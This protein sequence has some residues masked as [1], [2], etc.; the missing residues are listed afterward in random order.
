MLKITMPGSAVQVDIED[1]ECL[2]VAPLFAN[3]YGY[4]FTKDTI[5]VYSE[6][7]EVQELI[8]D[9]L[10]KTLDLTKF[11]KLVLM[12]E[13]E[14]NEDLFEAF[15]DSATMTCF[16]EPKDIEQTHCSLQ[17]L[18]PGAKNWIDVP[19]I[20]VFVLAEEFAAAYDINTF[21]Y[22]QIEIKSEHELVQDLIEELGP[23]TKRFRRAFLTGIF[24]INE[25]LDL[26]LKVMAN[27]NTID[28]EIDSLRKFTDK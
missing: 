26:G 16:K 24:K 14:T 3:A 6:E 20:D 8:N 17:A 1:E 27:G 13:D 15:K 5:S 23:K 11:L 4:E 12:A 22:N 18:M 21:D 9:Y 28:K 19:S 25:T 10:M 7:P 2:A